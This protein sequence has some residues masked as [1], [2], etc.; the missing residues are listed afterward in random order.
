M[1]RH[2]RGPVEPCS[3]LVPAHAAPARPGA[4]TI[5]TMPPQQ[6]TDPSPVGGSSGP[7]RFP[8]VWAATMD[9]YYHRRSADSQMG[10]HCGCCRSPPGH[11]ADVLQ[12]FPALR[13][14]S[15]VNALSLPFLRAS[16]NHNLLRASNLPPPRLHLDHACL[17]AS[18]ATLTASAPEVTAC[19]QHALSIRFLSKC[20]LPLARPLGVP[21]CVKM[22]CSICSSLQSSS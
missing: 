12:F 17:V 21:Y 20:I 22:C 1:L 14:A 7:N 5:S 19:F 4:H 10:G 9:R 18:P 8:F 15:H 11:G 16:A 13:P 3:A 2:C 6:P